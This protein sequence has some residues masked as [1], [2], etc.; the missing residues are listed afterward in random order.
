MRKASSENIERIWADPSQVF[1][2]VLQLKQVS[3]RICVDVSGR[4]QCFDRLLLLL[5]GVF[6]TLD[7]RMKGNG[8]RG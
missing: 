6:Q 3:F 1:Q 8:N 2:P 4:A 5:N 7:C